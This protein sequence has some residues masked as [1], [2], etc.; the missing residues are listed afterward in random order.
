[1]LDFSRARQNMIEGQLRP[2]RVTDPRLLAAIAD[3]PREHF[4]PEPLKHIAY[5]DDDIPLGRGRFLIEPLVI[6]RMLQV[7]DVKRTDKVLD[8]A[9]S[10]GYSTALL[11]RLAHDVTGLENDPELAQQARQ[12]LASV[13][14][15]NAKVVN[16]ALQDGW[17]AEAPY[18][19]IVIG[20]A[21]NEVPA[22]LQAQL[23]DGGRLLTV[24]SNG[25]VAGTARLLQRVGSS[26]SS[27][28]LFDAG[29][30]RLPGFD[31]RPNFVF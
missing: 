20:G 21:V 4:L 29:T 26:V 23:A 24:V 31:A 11:A 15:A 7:A 17:S 1:M 13:G 22:A 30:P 18:D 16:G 28:P 10:T 6:C 5:V 9:C 2:N 3:L 8:V 14:I 12:N 19:L 25:I 27:R